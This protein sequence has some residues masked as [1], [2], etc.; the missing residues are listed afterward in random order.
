MVHISNSLEK[1]CRKLSE[2]VTGNEGDIF[3]R[4]AIIT[5]TAG[6]NAWLKR[7]LTSINGSVANLSF[8]N[9]DRIF[10]ALYELLTGEGINNRFDI[11]KYRLFDLL[12]E[13]EF[14]SRFT[15]VSGYY[16][17]NELRRF[18]LAGKIAD[19]F[20]QYQ[21]YRANMV[22]NWGD[23]KLSTKNSA[24]EWQSWL[25]NRLGVP[26]RE[27]TKNKLMELLC[28]GNSAV[29]KKAFPRISF[30]GISVYTPYHL[31]VFRKLSEFTH[32]DFYVVLP[33][34]DES[35]INPLLQS[36]GTKIRELGKMF[37]EPKPEIIKPDEDTLL[38]SIQNQILGNANDL[39]TSG[40]ML[41]DG[42]LQINSCYTPAR[43]AESLY[44][45][46]L[47]LFSKDNTLRTR[48]VLIMVSDIARYAPYIKAVFKNGPVN[49]PFEVSGAASST[50]DS[51]ISALEQILIFEEDDFT[52]EKVVGLLEL[53]RI[54][55][56]FGL[57]DCSRIRGSVSKS[58]IRFGWENRDEDETEF[59]SWTQGLEKIILGHAML[60]DKEYEDKFPFRDSESERGADLLK[61]KSFAEK[62]HTLTIQKKRDLKSLPDW[63]HWLLT[64]VIDNLI[65]KDDFS[66]KDREE[67]NLI[68]RSLNFVD[69]LNTEKKYSFKV[70]L[71]ELKTRLFREIRESSL[72]T[73][74]VTFSAPVPV[75]GLPFRVIGF[76]GLNNGIFPARD[77]FAGFDL[78]GE[79]YA[80]GDRSRKETD[81]SIFLETILSARENLY[82]S[83]I[84]QSPKDNSK[85]PPSIVVDELL[86]YLELSCPEKDVSKLVRKGVLEEH[87]LHGF[88]SQYRKGNT[89]LYTYLYNSTAEE[90]ITNP[91]K[92]F[93]G[94]E[95][96][97]ITTDSIF[98]FFEHPIV[99]YFNNILK[100][101]Y[102][103][104]DVTLPES[105][106]FIPD[107]L[108]EWI[109][110]NEM[111]FIE[112]EAIN[113]YVLKN[114]KEAGL[115]LANLGNYHIDKFTEE[116]ASLKKKL[117]TEING[118]TET[119]CHVDIV[120]D[121]YRIRGIIDGV[122]GKDLIGFT[123]SKNSLK[124]RTKAFLKTLFLSCDA[125]II[126]SKFITKGGGASNLTVMEPDQ[127]K[128]QLLRIL[129][130]YSKGCKSPLIF[131]LEAGQASKKEEATNES[132][133]EKFIE[134]TEDND[135]SKN[136]SLQYMKKLLDDDFFECLTEDQ[137]N[138]I[139]ELADLLDIKPPK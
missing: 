36:C 114:K 11:I 82:L 2:S 113:D 73:G 42:S 45:Y 85:V 118:R 56:R 102:E 10:T 90:N 129:D 64:E 41:L 16:K 26:S 38:G 70:F 94:K 62:L 17:D 104:Q 78:L 81:K 53:K 138:D 112:D 51:V 84:G 30:F 29:I 128:G 119:S 87:P 24:E 37:P 7:E 122:Y 63:K 12:E 86:D 61:L 107:S 72:N 115:P 28:P 89:R 40:N 4:E 105:E 49:I 44:N 131:T 121:K 137:I 32:V 22:R 54:R 5:Q 136:K 108:Q 8:M 33:A 20:D 25:W 98:K 79:G 124:H 66:K 13:E 132:I 133:L 88:S 46:L 110:K 18:Q 101:Y 69:C 65:F 39:K 100:V 109:I 139:T 97:E 47:D 68:H 1:L 35:C 60:T 77:N 50:E 52:S 67:T 3:A 96:I 92:E 55:D 103:E 19:L 117:T 123:T 83:F 80:E 120:I 21:I 130:Y 31:E 6:M 106:M 116:T 23:N 71:D 134:E 125:K 15:L 95:L 9:Q 14:K 48:D 57:D 76:L 91:D 74:R 127:A 99:W 59:V 126:S 43:E 93:P 111:L 135:Y 34:S 75:R 58:G 27:E